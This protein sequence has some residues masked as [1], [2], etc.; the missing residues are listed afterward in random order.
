MQRPHAGHANPT[1]VLAARLNAHGCVSFLEGIQGSAVRPRRD[2][3]GQ[4]MQPTVHFGRPP[5]C[6]GAASTVFG[7]GDAPPVFLPSAIYRQR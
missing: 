6:T 5:E 3:S 2:W 4:T 1:C 7:R